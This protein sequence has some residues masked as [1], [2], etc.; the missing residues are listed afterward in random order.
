M[1]GQGEAERAVVLLHMHNCFSDDERA[2]WYTAG[3]LSV[4]LNM[5]P[6]KMYRILNY[7]LDVG[8]VV[9][10]KHFGYANEWR[11]LTGQERRRQEG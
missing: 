1:K 4:E 5:E 11:C 9:K 7:L 2:R 6:K 10:Q 8:K 3:Q